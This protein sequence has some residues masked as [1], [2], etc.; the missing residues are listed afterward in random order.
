M[1]LGTLLALGVL[2]LLFSGESVA[3]KRRAKRVK[4]RKDKKND[5]QRQPSSAAPWP[6]FVGSTGPATRR[7]DIPFDAEDP[8]QPHEAELA[9]KSARAMWFCGDLLNHHWGDPAVRAEGRAVMKDLE[10][11]HEG[12]AGNLRCLST[13]FQI[14]G[15][16]RKVIQAMEWQFAQP[17]CCPTEAIEPPG[18]KI[19]CRCFA[20][21]LSA[22]I[23]ALIAI[24]MREDAEN[25]FR[26]AVGFEIAGRKAVYWNELTQLAPFTVPGLTARP[27]WE[28]A[29]EHFPLARLLEFNHK[30]LEQ[31]LQAVV[32]SGME[33]GYSGITPDIIGSG[34]WTSFPLLQNM[35]WDDEHCSVAVNTCKLL[36]ERSELMGNS[37]RYPGDDTNKNTSVMITK[38]SPGTHLRAH[39]GGHNTQLSLH[40]VGAKMPANRCSRFN[41]LLA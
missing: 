22:H 41:F 37:P 34:N 33:W 39:T 26:R 20:F 14:F 36:R 30:R 32:E 16:H 18:A 15:E 12:Q 2:F 8:I 25:L 31:D 23:Y 21:T 40:L 11:H 4:S 29:G 19:P 24:G 17:W 10:T 7:T 9:G 3:A 6:R 1:Q 28:P 38:L 27:E 35:V 13:L 5:S